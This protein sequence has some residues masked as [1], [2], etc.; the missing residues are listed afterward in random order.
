MPVNIR[1]LKESIGIHLLFL[2]AL[3]SAFLGIYI[4]VYDLFGGGRLENPKRTTTNIPY[5]LIRTPFGLL[6]NILSAYKRNYSEQSH[7]AYR[8]KANNTQN[9][10][11][12]RKIRNSTLQQEYNSQRHKSIDD[13]DQIEYNPQLFDNFPKKKSPRLDSIFFNNPVESISASIGNPQKYNLLQYNSISK[14][15]NKKYD[16]VILVIS[17]KYNLPQHNNISESKNKNYNSVIP[18]ISQKNAPQHNSVLNNK[19]VNNNSVIPVTSHKYNFPHHNSVLNN[20]IVNNNSGLSDI[21]QNYDLRRNDSI[22]F[23]PI[24]LY[25][26]IN[27]ISVK[28]N[29]TE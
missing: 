18:V 10:T 16:S 15:K 4:T 2:L 23:K 7:T 1:Q 19:T 24:Q 12:K 22:G 9:H 20:K 25:D 5:D 13:S 29:I 6:D 11:Q 26:K 8:S 3:T 28:Y 14:S 17:Q 21:I 27:N